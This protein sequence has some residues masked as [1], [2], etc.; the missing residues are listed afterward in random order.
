MSARNF[1]RQSMYGELKAIDVMKCQIYLIG[2]AGILLEINKKTF[3]IYGLY[4]ADGKGFQ[5]S[6]IPEKICQNLLENTG[7]LPSPDYLLFSHPHFDHLSEKLLCSYLTGHRPKAVFLPRQGNSHYEACRRIMKEKQICCKLVSEDTNYKVGKYTEIRYIKTRH[8]GKTFGEMMH[9]CIIVN[10]CQASFLFTADTDFFSEKFKEFPQ[11]HF[12]GIFVNPL[13]YH[14]SEGQ[15]IL[16]NTLSAERFFVYHLPFL[17]D[18]RY[19]LQNMVKK[20]IRAYGQDKKVTVFASP[21][22]VIEYEIQK[23]EEK[24]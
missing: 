7:E 5:T 19:H 12:D 24:L 3:L 22:Q 18:D 10:V 6:P 13:F 20:D 2:N 8:L 11:K 16:K 1:R 15:E 14:N 23:G 9:F 21:G 4:S 17:E